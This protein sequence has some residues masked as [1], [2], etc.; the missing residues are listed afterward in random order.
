MIKN[1]SFLVILFCFIIFR[2]VAQHD[3]QTYIDSL[4][5]VYV[6]T[7]Q[8][9]TKIQ[10]LI[11]L[12]EIYYRTKP[13]TLVTLC[14]DAIKFAD[15]KL[16]K[17]LS[18]Q[19]K[20]IFIVNKASAYANIALVT[21][22]KGNLK[23]AIEY[24]NISLKLYK[25]V[26]YHKGTAT[27]LNNLGK[28]MKIEGELNH[29]IELYEE[30]LKYADLSNEKKGKAYTIGNIGAI[31][32]SNGNYQ[33]A[34]ENFIKAK[35]LHKEVNDIY[36]LTISLNNIGSVYRNLNML[37]LALKSYLETYDLCIKSGDIKQQANSSLKISMVYGLQKDFKNAEKYGL[38]CLKLTKETESTQVE[39]KAIKNLYDLYKKTNLPNKALQYHE[40]YIELRDSLN[41]EENQKAILE[42]RIQFDYD[43]QAIADSI[44]FEEQKKAEIAVKNLEIEQT[45]NQKYMLYGGL[46][47]FILLSIFIFNRYQ[48]SQKQAKIISTQKR[49]VEHQ[50][51]L[52]EEKNKEITDSINYA[53]RIQKAILPSDLAIQNLLPN[54]FIFYKP[55][56]IVAGDFYWVEKSPTPTLTDGKGVSPPT[57]ESEGA[58]ILFAAADC[59][60]HGVPGAL[61][62][63]VCSNALNYSLNELNTDN[64][65]AILE[66]TR[67]IVIGQ[68][69]KNNDNVKDGMDIAL[70]SLNYNSLTLK[71][72]GANN[73]LYIARGGKLL[74]YSSNRQPVGVHFKM[75]PFTQHE[76]QLQK[77]DTI[78]LFTD[79]YADQFGGE[80]GKKLK[81]KPFKE[82]LLTI[83]HHPIE[84]QKM[85][86]NKHF[87]EWKG[88]YE[89][90]DDVCVI[91]VKI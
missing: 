4:N 3:Q 49:Q 11:F 82:L 40:K 74:E 66:R 45:R 41:N 20:D 64:P 60:G 39:L 52:V 70:C 22:E 58:A 79:G 25:S 10:T 7:K 63:V 59:T 91:G 48:I 55:K 30:S 89:Q 69:S 47:V 33:A 19:E 67:E 56:D 62:S 8:D 87:T 61:V 85:F 73:N 13:D 17:K 5:R 83:S 75:T 42:Q 32:Y 71:Y 80:N 28:L 16:K 46:S 31:H 18:K 21:E 29:A 35:V 27:V 14:E 78:Y 77:G 54:S 53:K 9:T 44:K 26:N 6:T 38:L 86:L 24:N 15:E 51:I 23:K 50:K 43:K 57:G 84:E 72:S 68:F 81:Y 36:G 2:S 65:A 90:V 12:S 76:I 34:L 1:L 88:D 37:D